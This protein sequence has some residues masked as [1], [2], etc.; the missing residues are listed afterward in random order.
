MPKSRGTR[1]GSVK[2]SG[3]EQP[4]KDE[5]DINRVGAQHPAHG[6]VTHLVTF[7]TLRAA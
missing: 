6:G 7:R 4:I 5:A 2:A 3:W 1:N